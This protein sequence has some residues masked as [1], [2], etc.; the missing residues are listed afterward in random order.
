MDATVVADM[1]SARLVTV[2]PEDSLL[3]A[4]ELMARGG[5]HHLPVVVNGRCL[6]VLDDR[7]VAGALADPVTRPRRRVRDV[8]PPRVHCVPAD[9]PLH[10][11]ARIMRDERSTAVPVVDERMRLVGIVTDRDMVAAVASGAA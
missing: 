1:M 9:T 7:M 3:S 11:A 5:I 10:R 8:M 6:A 4:W 2:T